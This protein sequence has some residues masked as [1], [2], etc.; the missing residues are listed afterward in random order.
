VPDS[1]PHRAGGRSAALVR[2]SHP[3]PT[4]AVTA[5]ATALAV[6]AG[7][8]WAA[9]WVAAAV[10]SGQLSVG[11]SNDW[12]DRDRDV[13]SGRRDKP[14][15]RGDLPL[16]EVRRAA[17]TALALC[18][19]LSLAMGTAAGAAHLLAVAAA[20]GYN[21]R[22]KSTALSWA[23]YALAFGLVPSI[24]T[25]GLPGRPWA[26]WWATAA[27][28]LLGVGAHL[29]NALP[30]LEDDLAEGVRGLP[31]R[32]GARA[33]AALAALLLLGATALLALGPADTGPAGAAVLAVAVAVTG[34]GLALSRRPG[35][36]AA[37]RAAIV[38]AVL[39]VGLLV[40]RGSAI[41]A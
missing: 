26:P 36:R 30:D 21:L 35:S 10:L 28:A 34:T 6:S 1:L 7:R 15:A 2:A 12:V 29:A 23:P 41:A 31:H 8:G 27:G 32:L 16:A 11:W 5:V 17:L 13:R 24:V 19:P 38:V 18:V 14:V 4:V 9:A 37:F 22:L 39:D 40:T 33:S 25:L 20:W 3:E